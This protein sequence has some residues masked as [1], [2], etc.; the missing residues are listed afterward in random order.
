MSLLGFF[1]IRAWDKD[2][3]KVIAGGGIMSVNS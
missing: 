1:G 3:P 2:V